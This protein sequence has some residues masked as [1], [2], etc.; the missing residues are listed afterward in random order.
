MRANA[1]FVLQIF[2]QDIVA[3]RKAQRAL[4]NPAYSMRQTDSDG[5]Q[6]NR[7]TA[8]R[9]YILLA[10]RGSRVIHTLVLDLRVVLAGLYRLGLGELDDGARLRGPAAEQADAERR[11]PLADEF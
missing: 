11:E 2:F 3:H 7:S 5:K 10:C 1:P 9:S 4:L 8:M 6:D